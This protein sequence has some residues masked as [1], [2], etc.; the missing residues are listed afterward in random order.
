MKKIYLAISTFA[1]GLA[2]NAQTLTQTNNAFI[3]GDLYSTKQCDSLAIS[4]GASGAGASWN[5]AGITIH[6]SVLANYT[7]VASSSPQ[8][9]AGAVAVASG[10]SNQAYFL[11]S[12]SDLKYY[13]GNIAV[14]SVAASLTYTS[15]AISAIYP[16]SLNSASMASI[17]G[18]INITSP[19]PL[20]GTFNG[21]STTIADGSGTLT[22]PGGAQ[23]TYTNAL[24][25]VTS[26]TINYSASSVNGVVNRKNYDYYSPSN[27]KA[28]L[29]SISTITIT[30]NIAAANNQTIVTINKDYLQTIT[31]I[32]KNKSSVSDLLVYP[33]PASSM[34]NFSTEN[35]SVKEVHVFDITGKL[36]EKQNFDGSLKL[37]V[38][39]Y[40]KGLYIYSVLN[41]NG[42]TVKSGKLTVN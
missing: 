12:S 24:R 5:F 2:V 6:H 13:G 29:F 9:P 10:A 36:V 17:G 32:D 41:Q 19:L 27:M 15:G 28:P 14:Q 16:M 42:E 23:G 11:S 33:N 35:K 38:S 1:F 3:A 25:V 7:A 34:V 21:N 40:N 39:G 26:Q 30:S 8:Y 18:S 22:L 31:G 37:D 4:P 20:S